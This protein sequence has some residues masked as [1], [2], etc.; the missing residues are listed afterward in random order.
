MGSVVTV[1]PFETKEEGVSITN[2]SKYGLVSYL[3]NWEHEKPLHMSREIDA[4]VVFLNN[5]YRL[6]LG[7]PFD[8]PKES[9]YGREHCIETLREWSR[10][11]S[12]RQPSGISKI[13]TQWALGEIFGVADCEP[14][15][16]A[17]MACSKMYRGEGHEMIRYTDLVEEG[18]GQRSFRVLETVQGI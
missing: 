18:L 13:P 3:Y 8:G 7:T 17:R 10:A 12:I 15:N 2:E 1:T 4:G 14:Q 16:I 6:F 11:R 5:N 9:G